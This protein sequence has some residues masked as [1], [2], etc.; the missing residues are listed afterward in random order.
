M[1]PRAPGSGG[2]YLVGTLPVQLLLVLVPLHELLHEGDCHPAVLQLGPTVLILDGWRVKGGGE[3]G[4]A[5]T[6]R[7]G[8]EAWPPGTGQAWR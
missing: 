6:A 5:A 1:L 3:S 7:M 8:S 2:R 4:A